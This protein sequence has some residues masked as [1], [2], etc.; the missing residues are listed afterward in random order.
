MRIST[1]SRLSGKG[2]EGTGTLPAADITRT[3]VQH[4]PGKNGITMEWIPEKNRPE[5]SGFFME[6]KAPS[7]DLYCKK[8]R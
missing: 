6:G 4:F 7:A 8:R 3:L 5:F 2:E 1:R